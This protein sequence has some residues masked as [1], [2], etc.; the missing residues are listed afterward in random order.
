MQ[1]DL[2]TLEIP[3]LQDIANSITVNVAVKR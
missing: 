3:W 2:K 1:I